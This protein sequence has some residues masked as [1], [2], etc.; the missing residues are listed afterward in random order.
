M[1]EQLTEGALA[2]TLTAKQ[3][4]HDARFFPGFLISVRQVFDKILKHFKVAAADDLEDERFDGGAV[5]RDRRDGRRDIQVQAMISRFFRVKF[6]TRKASR[7]GM[8]DELR[9]Q[10]FGINASIATP[11]MSSHLELAGQQT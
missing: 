11:Y 6:G 7:V 1:P 10:G 5:P 9:R 2:D 3:N 4:E 8:G